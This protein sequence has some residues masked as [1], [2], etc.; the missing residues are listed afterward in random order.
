MMYVAKASFDEVSSYEDVNC[1]KFQVFQSCILLI[2]LVSLCAEMFDLRKLM[3]FILV[4]PSPGKGDSD[5][6]DEC[7]IQDPETLSIKI[8]ALTAE[9]RLMITISW[10]F[11]MI[12]TIYIGVL[13]TNFLLSDRDYV[14]LLLNAVALVFVFQ[15][16]ELLYMALGSSVVKLEI[17]NTQPIEFPSY[18]SRGHVWS[19]LLDRDFWG[20]ILLPLMVIFIVAYNV[21]FTT[22]PILEALTCACSQE[23]VKC[24]DAL[25]YDKTWFDQYWGT[26]IPA[27]M[28][29]LDQMHWDLIEKAK[30]LK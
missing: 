30:N 23:G 10:V 3:E 9:F 11:R 26:T 17:E 14:N 22:T 12:I 2:F 5:Q 25:S 28:G 27:A 1:L 6:A 20:L 15:I 7:V 13:G 29:Q 16:D 18:F 4:F 21:H 24:I 8:I 19:R